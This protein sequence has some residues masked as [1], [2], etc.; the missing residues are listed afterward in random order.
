MFFYD[1]RHVIQIGC[2]SIIIN[3][4]LN[5]SRAEVN[6]TMVRKMCD[7]RKNPSLIDQIDG[8]MVRA[9]NNIDEKSDTGN[10]F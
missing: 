4:L 10:G 3:A 6:G 8:L 7:V 9:F 2:N 5:D 1:F